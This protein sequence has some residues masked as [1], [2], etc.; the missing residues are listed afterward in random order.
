ME[1]PEHEKLTEVKDKSQLLGEFLEWALSKNYAFCKRVTVEEGTP[2]ERTEYQPYSGSVDKILAE[3]Y[4]ID[5]LKLES[6]KRQM[7][8]KIEEVASHP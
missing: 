3:F 4:E 5:L 1:Y 7:L 6:E 8:V 2:W